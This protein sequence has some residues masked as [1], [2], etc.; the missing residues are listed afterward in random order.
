MSPPNS[1]AVAPDPGMPRANIGTIAPE[2]AA[3][4]EDSGPATPSITPVPNFSGC[5]ETLFSTPYA[6]KEAIVGP[7]PG[8]QQIPKP[9]RVPLM[10]AHRQDQISAMEGKRSRNL[11]FIGAT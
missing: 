2:T 10:I 8:M 7:D 3:L 6:R 1:T 5:F 9:T 4:L 11:T